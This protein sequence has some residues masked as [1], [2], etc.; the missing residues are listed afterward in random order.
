MLKRA[1][2][3]V[4]ISKVLQE[5]LIARGI[6]SNRIVYYPNCIDPNIFNSKHFTDYQKN[7]LRDQYKIDR[8]AKLVTFVGTFGSWHGA[9]VLAKAIGL[10]VR[11]QKDLM[12]KENVH[13]M[14]VGDGLRMS[15]TKKIIENTG[16]DR[17]VTFT[18]LVPQNE[19]PIYLAS[20]T[21]F[22][23][24]H[25][26]N[27]DGSTFF[28]SPTKLFEYMAMGKAIVASN[29]GQIGE[30][31]QPSLSSKSLPLK[32]PEHGSCEISILCEPGCPK[33]LAR[34]IE[35]LVVR[36]DWTE[37]LGDNASKIALSKYTWKNHVNEIIGGLV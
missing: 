28:G 17:F 27:T 3:V 16:S 8:G 25:V 20:S 5:E 9:E 2:L 23:S 12:L 30:I 37:V 36:G 15:E 34:V 33:D 4:T 6:S 10:L 14:F 11:N 29:L 21:I 32:S 7:R 35:F 18:G 31:L 19:A 1:D 26:P 22:I 24:P 13:F